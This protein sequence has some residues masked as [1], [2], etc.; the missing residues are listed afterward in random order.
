MRGFCFLLEGCSAFSFL[1]DKSNQVSVAGAAYSLAWEA[2]RRKR[3]VTNSN[4]ES[5]HQDWCRQN[6]LLPE[7]CVNPFLESFLERGKETLQWK[8]TKTRQ[9]REEEGLKMRVLDFLAVPGPRIHASLPGGW[10][11]SLDRELRF[12]R[13]KKKKKKR[14]YGLMSVVYFEIY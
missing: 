2:K 1:E 13:P 11:W 4:S 9:G 12:S 7:F 8:L 10:V 3:V 6:F 5:G 14:G